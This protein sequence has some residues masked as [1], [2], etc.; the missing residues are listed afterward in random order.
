MLDT[1]IAPGD[2][3][4][5]GML[6]STSISQPCDKPYNRFLCNNLSNILLKH[7]DI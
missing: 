7:W 1:L 6:K 2:V 3:A 5:D 4:V